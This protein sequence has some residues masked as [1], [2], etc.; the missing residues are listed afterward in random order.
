MFASAFHL[1]WLHILGSPWTALGTLREWKWK[2]QITSYNYEICFDLLDPWKDLGDPR[3]TAFE[4]LSLEDPTLP[5]CPQNWRHLQRPGLSSLGQEWIQVSKT[6][7][8]DCFLKVQW[9]KHLSLFF[10]ETPQKSW[11]Q[12]SLSDESA[13]TGWLAFAE[14]KQDP[15]PCGL[16]GTGQS[17]NTWEMS[18]C[19]W[20]G[21]GHTQVP[22]K[23]GSLNAVQLHSGFHLA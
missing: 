9:E 8:H 20:E 23:A 17:G 15:L 13:T 1:L 2:R 5:S 16:A 4:T 3:R 14:G 12:V 18:S 22:I 7:R 10:S 11:Q 6:Q 21:S 19:P